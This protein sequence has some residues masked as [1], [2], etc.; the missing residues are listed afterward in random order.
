LHTSHCA[1]HHTLR[2]LLQ[3]DC[4]LAPASSSRMEVAPQ[5]PNVEPIVKTN[6]AACQPPHVAR[7]RRSPTSHATLRSCKCVTPA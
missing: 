4:Q 5:T 7:P 6:T 2:G 1:N 3:L